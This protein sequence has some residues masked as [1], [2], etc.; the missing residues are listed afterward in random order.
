MYVLA[1]DR[2]EN[3]KR[4][5]STPLGNTGILSCVCLRERGR[6][7]LLK[8]YYVLTVHPTVRL[9]VLDSI[10]RILSGVPVTDSDAAKLVQ[11]HPY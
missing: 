3:R 10:N 5:A 6:E 8:L 1:L 11:K 2:Y 9:L 7:T 4:I